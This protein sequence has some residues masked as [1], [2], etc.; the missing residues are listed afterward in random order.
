MIHDP[1]DPFVK[2]LIK[3]IKPLPAIADRVLYLARQ[4]PA[5]FREIARLIETDSLLSTMVIRMANSPMYGLRRSEARTLNRAIVVLGQ[6]HILDTV[7]LY[8]TRHMRSLTNPS[9]PRGDVSFWR[10][11]IGVAV[12]ARMLATRMGSSHGQLCFIAGLIHDIGKICLHTYDPVAYNEVIASTEDPERPLYYA[13]LE[14]FGISHGALSGVICKEWH[15][16]INCVNAVAYHHNEAD[17]ITV[18]V[19]N[20][21]R[22]AN[23]LVKIC[24]IGDSGNPYGICATKLLLPNPKFVQ[25]DIYKILDE[26][27][28]IVD[29]LASS[30]LG[31]SAEDLRHADPNMP[32]IPIHV[33]TRRE[34]DRLLLRYLLYSMGY[35]HGNDIGNKSIVIMDYMPAVQDPSETIIDF[36]EWRSTQVYNPQEELNITSLRKWLQN[37]IIQIESLQF[38]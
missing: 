34:S 19:A 24:G 12:A 17:F 31:E 23:L 29:E 27:P 37:K 28:I 38:A 11:N 33:H 20:I 7:G 4:N 6:Q 36:N 1:K 3:G 13:E 25:E 10:H 26:L 30:L 14:A 22:S 2:K 21:I 15:L 18:S 8:I 9:W 5:D 35:N 16:P 32:Q